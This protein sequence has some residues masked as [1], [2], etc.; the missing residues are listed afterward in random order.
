MKKITFAA[1]FVFICSVSLTYGQGPTS[2]TAAG[3]PVGSISVEVAKISKSLQSLTDRLKAFVDKFDKSQG[4]TFSEKQQNMLFGMEMLLKAEQLVAIL[5]K[6]QT[7][8]TEK[9]NETRG[10]LAQTEIDLRPRSIDRSVALIGTT[11]TEEI[12]DNKRQKL[13]AD[14]ESLNQL[15]AQLQ[16]SLAENGAKLRDAQ[17]LANNLRRQY[18][19][20]IEGET[21]RQP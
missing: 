9:L 17:N 19:P 3:D 8:L 15:M 16:Y 10:K 13:S 11:E 20:L 14:R 18:M 6:A 12:R 21:Q 2:A 7:D 5:Q 1:I 4:T